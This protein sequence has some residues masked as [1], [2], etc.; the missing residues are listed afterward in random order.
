MSCDKWSLQTFYGSE[1]VG[2]FAVISLLGTYP[3]VFGSG[4]LANLFTPIA[5][6]RGGDLSQN[7]KI[8]SANKILMAM[9]GI[10]VIGAVILII[11]F[12]VF[13]RSAVLLFSNESFVRYSYLLPWLTIAWA[14][15][16]LGQMFCTFG[17]LANQP[18]RYLMPKLLSSIVAL[19]STFYLSFRIGPVGVVW[20]LLLAGFI[21]ALWCGIIVLT[22]VRRG[23][24]SL[25]L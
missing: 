2:A 16:F 22:L 21:Y 8:A 5:F 14:F 9:T 12:A 7:H 4:F 3:L 11:F 13:H 24:E 10:Y 18:R 15:F 1:V 17:M 19:S 6:Q 25:Q 20:G 23:R